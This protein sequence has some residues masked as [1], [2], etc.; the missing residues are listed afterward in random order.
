MRL[1]FL[2]GYREQGRSCLALEHG[3]RYYVFD[4]GVKKVYSGGKYGEPPFLGLIDA[5]KVEAVFVSH[6]HED[7]LA[8]VPALVRRGFNGP[9][10]MSAPTAELG[11][12]QWYK[13]TVLEEDGKPLFTEEDC[14]EARKMVKTVGDGSVVTSGDVEVAFHQS[15]HALGSMYMEVSV[16]GWSM[17]YAADINRG[18]SVFRDPAPAP[19]SYDVVIA[20][21][22]YGDRVVDAGVGERRVAALVLETVK[23]GGT[24]LIPVTAVGRGQETLMILLRSREILGSGAPIFVEKSIAEGVE[25]VAAYEGYVKPEFLEVAKRKPHL[26]EPF[27]VFSKDEV[28]EVARV[29]PSVVLATDLMLMETSR[30]FFEKLREDPS[31]SVILTGYQAPGTFGRRLLDHREAGAFTFNGEVVRFSCRVYDVPVKMHFDVRDNVE[32][33][34]RTLK[35]EGLVV[36]HHGEEPNSTRLALHLFN[37]VKPERVVVPQ[38]PSD[39]YLVRS[40]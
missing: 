38:V 35:E 15:G 33:V 26:A 31:S 7:H 39:L 24:A 19:S 11:I 2:G 9:I 10:Y 29:K 20:N 13:W 8:A 4:V 23:R 16:G 37:Y 28:D 40:G 25:R 3:G 12:K 36:L 1:V 18:S 5:G 17:L 21:A 32:L 34:Q 22:S 27:H 6:L 30:R 14:D